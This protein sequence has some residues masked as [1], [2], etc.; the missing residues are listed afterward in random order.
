MDKILDDPGSDR[1]R[2]EL[3]TR[4]AANAQGLGDLFGGLL[5]A[6]YGIGNLTFLRSSRAGELFY[7]VVIFGIFGVPRLF[8]HFYYRRKFGYVK[9][10]SPNP[11][12]TVILLS[13]AAFALFL[14]LIFKISDYT[15]LQSSPYVV[16]PIS[17]FL[18]VVFLS[19][20]VVG[21]PKPV[22]FRI[23]EMTIYGVALT[24]IGL[25]PLTHL[26]TSQLVFN[27]WLWVVFGVIS[28]LSGV[29]THSTLVRNLTPQG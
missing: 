11:S 23:Y 1:E 16:E 21:R 15:R 10:P 26:Q 19:I 20:S 28:I 24:A 3:V 14:P 29:R 25:L 27:G 8:A 4:T 5:I 6:L 12:W 9:P 18:G 17:L 2:L 13:T 7:L 22:G